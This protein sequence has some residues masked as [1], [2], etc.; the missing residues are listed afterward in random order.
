[1]SEMR[2]QSMKQGPIQVI[3][4]CRFSYLATRGWKKTVPGDLA[5]TAEALYADDRM[6]ARLELFETLCLPSILGQSD[7]EIRLLILASPRMPERWRDLLEG[8]AAPHDQ[9]TIQYLRPRPMVEAVSVA[10]KR[11][12]GESDG[13]VAQFILDDDDAVDA[14]FGARLR[15]VAGAA[16]AAG[17]SGSRAPAFSFPRGITLSRRGGTFA[18]QMTVA[19]FLAQ[20]LAILSDRADSGENV[21]SVPHLRTPYRRPVWSDPAPI[22]YLRGVHDHHDSRG[23]FKGREYDLSP[24]E[25][26]GHLAEH[27]PSLDR[28]R[29]R[30]A[31][32]LSA[33]CESSGG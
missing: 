22:A 3:G 31:F 14:R 32:G 19:P 6:A 5:A 17:L 26:D 33:D 25:L 28:Q 8:L 16:R 27:F 29:V 30:A 2:G 12:L 9:V 15:E 1:M 20:G 18:A 21:Y 10:L 13:P 11:T 23:I 4:I 7:P 24:E